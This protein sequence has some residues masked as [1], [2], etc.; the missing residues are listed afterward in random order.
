M[1][2]RSFSVSVPLK[3]DD[4]KGKRRKGARPQPKPP[5]DMKANYQRSAFYYWW[6]FLREHPKYVEACEAGGDSVNSSRTLPASSVTLA[7]V[8][9]AISFARS[10]ARKLNS[11]IALS[12]AACLRV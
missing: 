2:T 6:A 1:P 11:T 4:A 5:R 8:R 3:N 10:P 12:R 7:M 9:A